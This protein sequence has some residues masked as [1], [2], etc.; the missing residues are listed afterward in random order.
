MKHYP[1][2]HISGLI[3]LIKLAY[4]DSVLDRN[5]GGKLLILKHREAGRMREA[6]SLVVEKLAWLYHKWRAVHAL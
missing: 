3:F 6:S 1:S 2:F 5:K 4:I